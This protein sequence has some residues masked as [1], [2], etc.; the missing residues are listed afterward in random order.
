[1]GSA[2]ADYPDDLHTLAGGQLELAVFVFDL[3]E[4][5]S[6]RALREVAQ[7]S[8]DG[9]C[10]RFIAGEDEVLIFFGRSPRATWAEEA[11]LLSGLSGSCP[12]T[13]QTG[14]TVGDKINVEVPGLR[15]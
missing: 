6:G 11:D 14:I 15:V 3:D 13:S 8:A 5:R 4:G 1:M 7:T 12:R 10:R 9:R 2:V